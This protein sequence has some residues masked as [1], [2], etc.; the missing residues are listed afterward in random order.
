MLEYSGKRQGRSNREGR[1]DTHGANSD[2]EDLYAFIS[3]R[4]LQLLMHRRGTYRSV[5][6]PRSIP[7]G[8]CDKATSLSMLEYSGGRQG[9]SDQ[10]GRL[11]V[12]GVNPEDEDCRGRSD[13]QGRH[14]VHGDKEDSYACISNCRLHPLIVL[15]VIHILVCVRILV[16]NNLIGIVFPTTTVPPFVNP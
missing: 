12:H 10:P 16:G 14:D 1:S 13:Q 2:K 15:G 11:D 8:R 6:L 5:I 9:R 3:H 4:P 7:Q